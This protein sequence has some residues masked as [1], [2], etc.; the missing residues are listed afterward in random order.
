MPPDGNLL[1]HLLR[2]CIWRSSRAKLRFSK[3]AFGKVEITLSEIV[4]H[5]L[6]PFDLVRTCTVGTDRQTQTDGFLEEDWY[7]RSITSNTICGDI[8]SIA[9]FCQDSLRYLRKATEN[10][11]QRSKTYLYYWLILRIQMSHPLILTQFLIICL[12]KF[13]H[14]RFRLKLWPK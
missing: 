13:S 7:E 6:S 11:F 3:T 5:R 10:I 12:T 14:L 1:T 2:R 9:L 4:F 8:Q